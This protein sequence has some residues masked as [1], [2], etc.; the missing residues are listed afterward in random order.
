MDGGGIRLAKLDARTTSPSRRSPIYHP[1]LPLHTNH[2]LPS[3]TPTL[4]VRTGPYTNVLDL[5]LFP[6]MS[7]RHS[8]QLQLY[9]N[10]E[11]D[12]QKTWETVKDVWASTSSAEVARSFVL[13]F[14]VMR[15]IIEENGYNAWLAS[16]T[17]H[18]HVRRDYYDTPRGI[19]RKIIVDVD[20]ITEAATIN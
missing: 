2:P 20:E 16:G 18:C 7:H 6:S 9:N 14:R 11:A 8:E 1:N 10:T 3:I 19:R 13:A 17:P 15:L 12:L 4:V 5:Y